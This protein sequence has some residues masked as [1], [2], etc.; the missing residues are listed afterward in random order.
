MLFLQSC[1]MQALI[2]C[3][4]CSGR[5]QALHYDRIF[6][7]YAVLFL[8]SVGIFAWTIIHRFS[9]GGHIC[10]G[11]YLDTFESPSVYSLIRENDASQFY[12][13]RQGKLLKTYVVVESIFFF[14]C[15]LAGSI[16]SI[17]TP[18]ALMKLLKSV[19]QNAEEE[20]EHA[21]AER[22]AFK[23]EMQETQMIIH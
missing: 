13:V 7:I 6:S 4:C 1:I 10:S 5:V 17:C 21:I 19:D 12:L 8:V 15:C 23:F 9:P 2:C 20:R 18:G 11:D 3:C 16:W 22:L 14:F